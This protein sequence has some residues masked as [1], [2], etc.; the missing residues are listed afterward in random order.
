MTSQT[1]NKRG[2]SAALCEEE[3]FWLSFS[4]LPTRYGALWHSVEKMD[5]GKPAST[6]RP[7]DGALWHYVE[8]WHFGN[9][10]QSS[11]Q[12]G[13]LS[14]IMWGMGILGDSSQSPHHEGV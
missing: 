11:H 7:R 5:I 4:I 10:S 13:V 9:S 1:R 12:K 6:P 8:D 3:M 14:G 2:N